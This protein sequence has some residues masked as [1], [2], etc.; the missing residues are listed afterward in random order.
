MDDGGGAPRV[1]RSGESSGLELG[2][3]TL[4][5]F[6]TWSAHGIAEWQTYTDEPR[7]HGESV[8]AGDFFTAC[9]Q[10]TL[11]NWQSEFLQLFHLW[12]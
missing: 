9:S 3:I 8:E 11:E 5:F 1:A 6:A 2:P 10:S 7:E 12:Y 4:F